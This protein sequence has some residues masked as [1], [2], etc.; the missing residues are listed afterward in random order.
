MCEQGDGP[1][2]RPVWEEKGIKCR[3]THILARNVGTVLDKLSYTLKNLHVGHEAHK[4][5]LNTQA[6]REM[7]AK[8]AYLIVF[9]FHKKKKEMFYALWAEIY[10]VD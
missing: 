10:L 9:H 4:N 7:E 2:G 5:H 8:L 3:N 6:T 1:I